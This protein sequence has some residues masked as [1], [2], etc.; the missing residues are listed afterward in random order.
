MH[1][2]TATEIGQL[3]LLRHETLATA[4]SCTG[5]LI[6]KYCTDVAGSSAWFDRGLVTYSNQAK[7]DLLG[8]PAE[9]F[10]SHG[11]VSEACVTAMA[12][13]LLRNSRV[14]WGIAVTGIA[15]PSGGSPDKPVGTVWVACLR[16]GGTPDV[17]QFLFKGNREQVREETALKALSL[18]LQR[19]Q[20]A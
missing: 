9:I 15:G 1:S 2:I 14:D 12:E 8:V 10:P 20:T 18:L 4:E 3:L 11:A 13:G 5:G 16:R 19:L 17:R 7:Q 6:A